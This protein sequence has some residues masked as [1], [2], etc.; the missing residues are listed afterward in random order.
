MTLSWAVSN[1]TQLT[2]DSGSGPFD[3]IGTTSFTDT[4]STSTTYTLIATNADGIS[5]TAN[6]TLT[7]GPPP[8]EITS[9]TAD[10][11]YLITGQSTTLSWTTGNFDQL[12]LNPDAVDVT[13]QNSFPITPSATTTYTLTGSVAGGPSDTEELTVRVGPGRPNIVIFLVDDMGV[14]RHFCP[15]HFRQQWAADCE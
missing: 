11:P 5:V 14:D 2:L 12:T 13:G 6:V 1:A 9:F 7:V 3:V 4:P 15:V 8:L 10:D